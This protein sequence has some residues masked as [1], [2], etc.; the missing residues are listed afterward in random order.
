MLPPA[1][2]RYLPYA[3]FAAGVLAFAL[4]V[5][6][7]VRRAG[8]GKRPLLL[9]AMIVGGLPALYVGLGWIGLVGQGWLR[10]ERPQL[11]LLCALA[12]S[13]VCIRLALAGGRAGTWR[14]RLGDVLTP[15]AAFAAAMATTGPEIGRPLDRLTVLV[16]IDR[17]RSID[18]VPNA[19]KRIAQELSVAE[20]GMREDD[21]IGTIA[22]GADAATEDPP[23]PK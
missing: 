4:L 22:F 16:A 5:M 13:F 6:F 17:S 20:I 7:A 21:A 18:L 14:R 3:A 2:L 9:A 11:T 23:R 15:L 12:V 1:A 8:L 10:L 19:D